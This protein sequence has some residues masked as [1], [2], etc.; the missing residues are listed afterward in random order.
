MIMASCHC[1]KVRIE[2]QEFPSSLTECNCSVCHRYGA[3]WAY[4]TRDQVKLTANPDSVSA[5]SWG[6]H[7]IEFCHCSACGCL[8]HYESVE[9]HETSRFAINARMMPPELLASIPIR[10]FDGA[11]SWKYID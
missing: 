4:F 9:K 1:G 11:D 5:Y 6:D 2:V 8:T 10:K 7:T 3:Q